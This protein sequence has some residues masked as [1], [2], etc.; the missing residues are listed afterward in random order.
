MIHNLISTKEIPTNNCWL[1]IDEDGPRD[2]LSSSGFG[3][4]GV[5]R[6][7][8]NANVIVTGHHAVW[9]NAVLETV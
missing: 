7:I 2:M 6:V 9:A 4:E 8:L 3:E 1:Q 5:V